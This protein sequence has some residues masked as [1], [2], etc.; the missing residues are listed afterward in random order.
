MVKMVVIFLCLILWPLNIVLNF[1]KLDINFQNIFIND[2]QGEQLVLRK[3][4]LYPNIPLARFFQNKPRI[5]VNKFLNNFFAITDPN[6]YFFAMHPEPLPGNLNLSKFPFGAI[7]FFLTGLF[8]L[9]KSKFRN[10]ILT[11]TSIAILFLSLLIKHEGIDFVLWLPITL[12]II[13]GVNVLEKQ[14]INIFK[15]YSFF[16]VVFSIPEIIRAFFNV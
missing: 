3:I 7:V 6:N 5:Y 12:I 15:I 14:N 11:L 4:H 13:N 1:N 8:Y 10:F 9:N 2:Y 16:F